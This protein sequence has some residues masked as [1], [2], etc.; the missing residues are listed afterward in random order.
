[1]IVGLTGGIGSGKSTVADFFA[2]LGVPVFIADTEGKKLM[3]TDDAVKNAIVD[4]FGEEAY[5]GDSPNTTY[6]ADIVFKDPEKLQKLNKIIHP[7]VGRSFSS[8]MKKQEAP[9]VIKEAAILFESGSYKDCDIVL[10]VTAPKEIRI[11][12]VL[13]RDTATREAIEA[14]MKNQWSEEEKVKKSDFIIENI[15]LDTTKEFVTKVHSLIL[16]K[17][18]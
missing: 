12:R 5:K 11:Q 9:Y 17:S 2:E 8:W 4:E 6:I 18:I 15:N 10:T 1:M 13:Q 16:K 3:H 7:A 14:R